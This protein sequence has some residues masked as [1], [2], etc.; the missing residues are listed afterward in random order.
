MFTGPRANYSVVA[1][2]GRVT[3]TDNVG[4]D[5]ID[6]LCNIERLQFTDETINSPVPTAGA[7]VPT[8]AHNQRWRRR[9]PP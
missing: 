4:T 6:T 5:G 8:V 2:P 1:G 3:V 9:R 7:T